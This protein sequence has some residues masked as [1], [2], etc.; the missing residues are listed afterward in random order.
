M[1]LSINIVAV[2]VA[3]VAAFAVGAVW[4]GPLFGKKWQKIVGLSDKQLQDGQA[5]VFGGAFVLTF[6]MAVALAMFIGDNDVVYGLCA[7]LA[8]GV[9]IVATAFGVNYL[10]EHRSLDF[11]FVNA[12]YNVVTL[13]IIGAILGAF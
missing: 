9:G 10:F 5:K 1:D 2:I 3:A 12:G 6:I 11:Y 13:A 4:Y 8:A 7:G